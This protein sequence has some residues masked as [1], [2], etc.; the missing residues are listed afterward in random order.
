MYSADKKGAEKMIGYYN[1]TVIATYVGLISAVCGV[2]FVISGNLFAALICLA[3]A[4]FFDIFDGRIARTRNSTKDEHSFGIQIDSLTDLVAFG[5]LPAAIGYA[6]CDK[7]IWFIPIMCAYVLTGLIR[8]AYF[9]V[10]EYNRQQHS[11]EARHIYEGLPITAAALIFPLIWCF[12]SYFAAKFS[13]VYAV[14]MAITALLFITPFKIEKPGL[15]GLIGFAILGVLMVVFLV[16][17]Q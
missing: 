6:L 12:K 8:L 3:L 7:A 5:V 2:G 14:V 15:K 17:H 4:G 11:S 10:T 16:L 9:N 13:Y 1:Y